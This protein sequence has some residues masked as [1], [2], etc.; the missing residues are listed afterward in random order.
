MKSPTIQYILRIALEEVD[1]FW[2]IVCEHKTLSLLVVLSI[3]GIGYSLEP[4]APKKVTLSGYSDIVE[5]T[6]AYMKSLG[7][8]V[9][10]VETGGTVENA[11]RL[12]A[13][14]EHIDAAF[15]QGGVLEDAVARRLS[16][17]GGIAYEP[18][19]TFYRESLPSRPTN[20]RQLVSLRMGIGPELAG[21]KPLVRRLYAIEGIDIDKL[22]NFITAPSYDKNIEDLENGRL[23]G[24]FIVNPHA[25]PRV[26]R[27]L[28]NDS[29]V[30]MNYGL[31]EAYHKNFNFLEVLEVPK[32]SIDMS[33]ILPEEDIKLVATTA[34]L[35]VSD[36]LNQ[37]IQMLLLTAMRDANRNQ[38]FTF[39]RNP[40]GFPRYIDPQIPLSRIG[41][42]FYDY[43]LP[44][45]FRYFPV[46]IA[47]FV[48]RYW[49]A[50]LGILSAF[51]ALS[52]ININLRAS[53]F[54]VKQRMF[55]KRLL[56]IRKRISE[57][58]F[59]S[60]D[61]GELLQY[62]CEVS[63]LRRGL[64][65]AVVPLGCESDYL[66]MFSEIDSVSQVVAQLSESRLA[67]DAKNAAEDIGLRKDYASGD[68][69][70]S[71]PR[72]QAIS[73]VR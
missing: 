70:H 33:K 73:P 10:I 57:R 8:E 30:L 65:A 2:D 26:R 13:K 5:A 38:K 31:A 22:D 54:Y 56:L 47:G 23:D 53:R 19:W 60:A 28:H 4:F 46:R 66:Q 3:A 59:N 25:D 43:G 37:D 48:D 7:F 32:G 15:I 62:A 71:N 9:S 61:N 40:Q 44:K 64:S 49:V 29:L 20:L 42:H 55:Y 18:V 6:A 45:T 58:D 72:Y 21:T 63:D 50:V 36:S 16:S 51:V 1:A 34:S 24:L 17:L 69:D 11:G 14:S 68:A 67:D 35:V 41:M 12:L 27:L 52:K 39:F